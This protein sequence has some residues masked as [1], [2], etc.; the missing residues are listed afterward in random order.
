[1]KNEEGC[2][3][4]LVLNSSFEIRNSTFFSYREYTLTGNRRC[5]TGVS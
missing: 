3:L 5:P 1:M 2:D 4:A